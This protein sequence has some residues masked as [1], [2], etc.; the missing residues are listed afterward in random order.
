MCIGICVRKYRQNKKNNTTWKFNYY[1]TNGTNYNIK[2][3]IDDNTCSKKIIVNI[4]GP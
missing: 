1:H 4:I 3:V 2:V